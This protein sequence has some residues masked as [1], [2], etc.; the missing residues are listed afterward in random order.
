MQSS[1][2]INRLIEIMAALRKPDTG[3]AWDLA[4]SFET[5]VPYTIEESYEVADAVARG[6]MND[7][8]EELGD[9]LLQVVFQSRIAE[10]LNFFDFGAVVEA[11]TEKML[12]RH[13][14]VFGTVRD[15]AP[16]ELE[17]LWEQ[18]KQEERTA[19][20]DKGYSLVKSRLDGVARALP[21]LSRAV[22][23]QAKASSAGFDWKEAEVVLD[24]IREETDEIAEALESG[25]QE[26]IREE[27]GDLLFTVAN[28]ARHVK[29]DPETA[30]RQ[31]NTKFERRFYFI[32][33]YLAKLNKVIDEVSFEEMEALWNQVR[34]NEKNKHSEEIS[35]YIEKFK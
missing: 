7:L 34:Q 16:E 6:D 27:I 24:K 3:C 26:S 22:K 20:A 11:I 13:P 25:D 19:K 4:Q 9:L 1:R 35:A 23:L 29:I 21:G 30:I 10:E 28:L 17:T 14:H 31:A 5:I 8:K 18:I 2:H 33:K 32:E 15:L 12:R